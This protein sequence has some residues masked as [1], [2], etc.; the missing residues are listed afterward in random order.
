MLLIVQHRQLHEI[1]CLG[2]CFRLGEDAVGWWHELGSGFGG[3]K[4][5]IELT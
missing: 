3:R 5:L 2:L 4:P 1:S